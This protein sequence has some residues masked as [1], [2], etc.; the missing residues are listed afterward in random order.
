MKPKG[1]IL[2]TVG[3]TSMIRPDDLDRGFR[4]KEIYAVIGSPIQI[5]ISNKE[6]WILIV[7]EEAKPKMMRVNKKATDLYIFGKYDEI[8]GDVIFCPTSFVK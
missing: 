4:L 7:N 6:G 5:L 1:K 3:R 8:R 2:K